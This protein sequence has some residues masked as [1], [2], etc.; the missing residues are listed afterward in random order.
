MYNARK[1][2]IVAAAVVP[3][4]QLNLDA[5]LGEDVLGRGNVA[6]L[7]VKYLLADGGTKSNA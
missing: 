2:E 4:P 7:I 1:K 6:R 5:I 3:P